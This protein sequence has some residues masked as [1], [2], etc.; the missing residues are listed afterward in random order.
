MPPT[1]TIREDRLVVPDDPTIP[2]IEGDGVGPEL[3]RAASPA[4]Q[5][6]TRKTGREIAFLPVKAGLAALEE[7][8]SH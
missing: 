7:T 3:W 8:G 5:A 4:I 1:I 2:V 6:A